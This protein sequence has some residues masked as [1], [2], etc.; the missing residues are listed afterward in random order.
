MGITS[1]SECAGRRVLTPPTYRTDTRLTLP[2]SAARMASPAQPSSSL[3]LTPRATPTHSP[4]G[5]CSFGS[6]QVFDFNGGSS[7]R[8]F[9][10]ESTDYAYQIHSFFSPIA[11][12]GNLGA[13]NAQQQPVF[14][15]D[16][17]CASG[18]SARH[19]CS[20]AAVSPLRRAARRPASPAVTHLSTPTPKSAASLGHRVQ[21]QQ[22][23][24]KMTQMLA[25][26]S[27]QQRTLPPLVAPRPEPLG[28]GAA[29]KHRR[30]SGGRI[31]VGAGPAIPEDRFADRLAH[32]A[33]ALPATQQLPIG[34]VTPRSSDKGSR[35]R[36]RLRAQVAARDRDTDSS[37]CALCP[38]S[39]HAHLFPET[40]HEPL[41][42][43][44][45]L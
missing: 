41:G 35:R 37:R 32:D 40:A 13:E 39:W 4:S 42:M 31:N 1:L 25:T 14:S 38:I 24:Q 44:L 9:T 29:S 17:S 36:A 34:M 19:F 22:Q 45:E 18:N 8:G 5:D 20:S 43:Q 26:P 10:G 2:G 12:A 11:L 27:Q 3:L 23:Q 21:Q 7:F 16:G 28:H 15:P 6:D 33:S 30:S